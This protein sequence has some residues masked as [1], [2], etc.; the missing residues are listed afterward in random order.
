MVE[1]AGAWWEGLGEGELEALFHVCDKQGRTL[2]LQ[3]IKYF[4]TPEQ[5]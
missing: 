5:H 2:A 3:Y 1:W 4:W